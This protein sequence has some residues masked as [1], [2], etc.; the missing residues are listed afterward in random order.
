MFEHLHKLHLSTNIIPKA[1]E[2]LINGHF[3]HNQAFISVLFVK[4]DELYAVN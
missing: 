2:R 3:V 1:P 4:C